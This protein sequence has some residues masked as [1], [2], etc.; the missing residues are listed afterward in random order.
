TP[1]R[2]RSGRRRPAGSRRRGA[3]GRTQRKQDQRP[4]GRPAIRGSASSFM[5]RKVRVV[6]GPWGASCYADRLGNRSSLLKPSVR[7]R[8]LV[9]LRSAGVAAALA[10]PAFSAFLEGDG[11][12][13]ERG[14]GISPPPSDKRV[15]KQP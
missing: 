11:G 6:Q 15:E 4:S 8:M 3:A 14:G 10:A 7:R 2:T 13:E 5:H 9:V 1:G 12:D